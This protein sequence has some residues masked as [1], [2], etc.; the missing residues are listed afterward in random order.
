M[1]SRCSL[2][3]KMNDTWLF[4]LFLRKMYVEKIA[5]LFTLL[6]SLSVFEFS[7]FF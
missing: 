4:F 7:C 3:L 1:L 6:L 2:Y 5:E